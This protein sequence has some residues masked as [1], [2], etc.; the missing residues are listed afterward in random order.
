MWLVVRSFWMNSAGRLL[1]LQWSWNKRRHSGKRIMFDIIMLSDNV[2]CYSMNGAIR[3]ELW[4]FSLE[5][6]VNWKSEISK[7]R[8]AHCNNVVYIIFYELLCFA[9]STS[10]RHNCLCFYLSIIKKRLN[11]YHC[12]LSLVVPCFVIRYSCNTEAPDKTRKL[13]LVCM[14][15]FEYFFIALLEENETANNHS[16]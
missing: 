16:T 9:N 13:Y 4:V 8:L 3:K 11:L 6:R 12:A 5:A 1:W 10:Y 7:C 2:L 15:I 14:Q